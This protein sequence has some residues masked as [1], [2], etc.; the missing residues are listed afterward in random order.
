MDNAAA[1]EAVDW[2]F[3]SLRA[4]HPFP[5]DGVMYILR[6]VVLPLLISVC[7]AAQPVPG[8]IRKEGRQFM[9]IEPG[10]KAEPSGWIKNL[11]PRP[12]LFQQMP[13]TGF[14]YDGLILKHLIP[15]PDLRAQHFTI[16]DASGFSL[17]ALPSHSCRAISV[18]V[19][20]K[21]SV[22]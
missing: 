12:V 14:R 21:G 22:H 13:T 1:F 9:C 11:F 3:E 15:P 17:L 2:E 18:Y 19:D 7:V 8:N 6:L 16:V 20:E 10:P 5:K 4:H